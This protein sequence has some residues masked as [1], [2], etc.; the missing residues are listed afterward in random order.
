MSKKTR[1][2]IRKLKDENG[3]YLLQ[4]DINS[5]FGSVLLG[6]DVYVS[7]NMPE[8]G[9]GNTVIYFGDYKGLASKMPKEIELEILREKYADQHLLGVNAWLELDAKV[10]DEQRLAKLVVKGT[11]SSNTGTGT[12]N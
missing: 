2:A 4:D 7:D 9:A 5:A 12:G 8:I 11:S 10:Q 6:K 3:R 1:T